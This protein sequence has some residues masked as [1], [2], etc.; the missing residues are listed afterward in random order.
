MGNL[1]NEPKNLCEEKENLMQDPFN[2]TDFFAERKGAQYAEGLIFPATKDQ[3]V[4]HAREKHL[5]QDLL[6]KLE[7]LPDRKYESVADMVVS[8]VR[9]GESS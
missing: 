9:A 8:A 5:P 2:E 1:T 6:R 3:I 4:A 7:K